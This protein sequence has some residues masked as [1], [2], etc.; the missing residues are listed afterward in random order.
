MKYKWGI[1]VGALI[2]IGV[3][4]FI[5]KPSSRKENKQVSATDPYLKSL[6]E[7][8]LNLKSLSAGRPEDDK[9]IYGAMIRLSETQWAGAQ[10]AALKYAT[11]ES[12]YLREGAAQ[13]L[14][15]FSESD[16]NAALEKLL[17]DAAPTVRDYALKAIGR[18][19]SPERAEMLKTQQAKIKENTGDTLALL[20][21][22]FRILKADGK[23]EEQ[24]TLKKI[25]QMAR[26]QSDVANQASLKLIELAPQW[27]NTVLLFRTK[28]EEKKEPGITAAGIRY[29]AGRRDPWLKDKWNALA[30]NSEPAVV[31]AVIQSMHRTC[32]TDREDIMIEIATTETDPTVQEVVIDETKLLAEPWGDKV[33]NILKPK[34]KDPHLVMLLA[35]SE[36]KR[37]PPC[38]NLEK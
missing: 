22:E 32:P 6:E 17:T 21:S 28:V 29:L 11:S 35:S 16:S 12:I 37:L 19:P 38:D 18:F 8:K 31:K 7:D 34:I 9:K 25:L 15:Y 27:D 24:E 4:F 20:E 26:G 13:A 33:L 10:D 5:V 14:G 1:L 30:R 2:A 23:S 36:E 3:I